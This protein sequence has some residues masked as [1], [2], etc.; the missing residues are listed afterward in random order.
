MGVC[1]RDQDEEAGSTAGTA[2]GRTA[3]VSE[4]HF[5]RIQS[6]L[7]SPWPLLQKP[8]TRSHP[9]T[10]AQQCSQEMRGHD[11]L[12]HVRSTGLAISSSCWQPWQSSPGS[13]GLDNCGTSCIGCI[14]AAL[15]RGCPIERM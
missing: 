13:S 7:R 10:A 9:P 14:Q 2:E 12:F 3:I 8:H 1:C 11:L 15:A 6:N 4:R 5:L